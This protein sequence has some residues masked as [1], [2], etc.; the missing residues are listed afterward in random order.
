MDFIETLDKKFLFQPGQGGSYSS[1]GFVVMGM[2]LSALTGAVRWTDLDQIGALG[3]IDPPLNGTIF[4]HTGKCSQYPKVVHQYA[5]VYNKIKPAPIPANFTCSSKVYNGH[6]FSGTPLNTTTGLTD[7][8]CCKLSLQLAMDTGATEQ[9]PW[10][11]TYTKIFH[12]TTDQGTCKVYAS[13]G[14]AT[15]DS[16]SKLGFSQ[17]PSA[18]ALDFDDLYSTSCLNGW[19]M[20]NIA[21][22][23]RDVARF[24]HLLGSGKLVS[25]SSL[26]QM[27]DF[28]PLTTGFAKGSGYGLGLF[29]FPT[30]QTDVTGKTVNWTDCWGHP[31]EDWGSSIQNLGFYPNLKNASMALATNAIAS[32]N[33]TLPAKERNENYF[34]YGVYCQLSNAV[35]QFLYPGEPALR[36]GGL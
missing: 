25:G 5:R 21:V 28:K 31:G 32:M 3:T 13:F 1:D 17:P 8:D 18:T 19:T 20:G 36:C 29:H 2:V 14:G 12:K 11:M 9:L 27:K 35:F 15:Q 22:T 34:G 24:Y 6:G 10:S 16:Y 33:F 26:A 4:M 23:A 30:R 7:T